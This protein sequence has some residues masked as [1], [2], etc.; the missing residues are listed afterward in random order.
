MVFK[1]LLIAKNDLVLLRNLE[2]TIKM[3]I[4]PSLVSFLYISMMVSSLLVTVIYFYHNWKTSISE[5]INSI[6]LLILT[7]GVLTV[8][9]AV[10]GLFFYFPHMYRTGF[11]ALL[12]IAPLLYL[13]INFIQKKRKLSFIHFLHFLPPFAYLVNFTPLFLSSSAVKIA[14]LTHTD[15]K[16]FSEGWFFPSYF[17]LILCVSQVIFYLSLT[18][19]K[20][21]QDKN[22]IE[23]LSPEQKKLTYNFIVYLLLFLLPP[24][25]TFFTNFSGEDSS[26]L[27]NII[28]V[29]APTLF[30]IIFLNQP[31][32]IYHSILKSGQKR[33]GKNENNPQ[34]IDEKREPEGLFLIPKL[35]LNTELN[36]S[37]A[38][39]L[40]KIES[41]FEEEKPYLEFEFTQKQLSDD[42]LMSNYQIRNTLN[43]A[44]SISFT[45]YVNYHRINEFMRI[46]SKDNS[47][48]TATM[49][50]LSN[51]IGFKS[52]NSF[53]LAFKK[54]VGK[55]PKEFL[56]D[57]KFYT[58]S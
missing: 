58:V 4:S 56:D 27:L 14:H 23:K 43:Q 17:V 20:L 38:Y 15:N 22:E 10:Q 37:I 8:F 30:F 11:L 57:A 32:F 36:P 18:I 5:K 35:V 33:F 50:S 12:I 3:N 52:V 16:E 53:Y 28:Y 19:P 24:F 6:I 21:I 13:N 25:S 34:V 44:Y 26:S 54:F 49:S 55:T 7:Y 42:L 1:T 29:S 46:L 2:K 47:W 41:Y 51:S 9:F 48:K 40:N 31:K 45:D 39:I